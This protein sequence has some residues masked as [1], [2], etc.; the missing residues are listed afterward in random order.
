M[1]RLL[2]LLTITLIAVCP[3][4]GRHTVLAQQ[5]PGTVTLRAAR[6]LDGRGGTLQNAVV[7]ISGDRIVRVDQRTGPVT[8]DLGAATLLPGMIDT[9]VH[10]G[11]PFREG[12]PGAATRARRPSRWRCS[13]PRTHG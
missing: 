4:P 10:I 2:T 1:R 8:V 5:P 3:P 13:P 12:R 6:V 9:H 7:E 11:Y